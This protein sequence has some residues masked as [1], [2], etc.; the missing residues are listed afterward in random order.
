MLSEKKILKKY[1]NLLRKL[2]IAL[3]FL[4]TDSEN[5]L[6]MDIY[7]YFSKMNTNAAKSIIDEMEKLKEEYFKQN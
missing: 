3:P 2:Y 6:R 1:D 4:C 5:V 7:H